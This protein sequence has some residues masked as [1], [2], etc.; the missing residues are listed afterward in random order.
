MDN[1]KLICFISEQRSC[2]SCFAVPWYSLLA[3][4]FLVLS[5]KGAAAAEVARSKTKRGPPLQRRAWHADDV[6]ILGRWRMQEYAEGVGRRTR[7][8]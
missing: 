1:F 5:M 6:E 8:L 7:T 2:P 3:Y 4:F